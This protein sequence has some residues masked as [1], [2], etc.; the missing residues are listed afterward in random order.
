MKTSVSSLFKG[1]A[2]N[3]DHASIDLTDNI[4]PDNTDIHVLKNACMETNKLQE[5]KIETMNDDNKQ[6]KSESN[7]TRKL[8][9]SSPETRIQELE[10]KNSELKTKI[11][12]LENERTEV[13]EEKTEL[14]SNKENLQRQLE[15]NQSDKTEESG[16]NLAFFKEEYNKLTKENEEL[17]ILLDKERLTCDKLVKEKLEVMDRLAESDRKVTLQHNEVILPVLVSRRGK[18]LHC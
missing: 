1:G 8:E 17:K 14:A 7:N 11:Q 15:L 9:Q 16:R 18:G 3:V 5:D 4:N 12:M 10:D 13:S 2:Q 6:T